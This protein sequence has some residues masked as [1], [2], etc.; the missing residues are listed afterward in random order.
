MHDPTLSSLP[1]IAPLELAPID[2]MTSRQRL[3][4]Y[5]CVFFNVL[6]GLTNGYDICVTS[7]V[8]EQMV[9]DFALCPSDAGGDRAP[10][11]TSCPRKEAVLSL[12]ATG[13]LCSKLLLAWLADHYGRRLALA[14]VDCM[15]IWAVLLQCLAGSAAVLLLGRFV[16]GVGIGLSFVVEPTYV[17]EIAPADRRGQFV[18]FN[19][20]AVCIGCLLGLQVSTVLLRSAGPRA[21]RVVVGIGAIPACVQLLFLPFL[22]ESPRWLAVQRKERELLQVAHKLGLPSKELH[23]LLEQATE[24]KALSTETC[25]LRRLWALQ[26]RAWSLYKTAF[27]MALG[28]AFFNTASGIFG[29]QAYARDVLKFSGVEKPLGLLPLVGWVKLM[30]SLVAVVC[31]D[32][33]RAGRRRLALVGST[34]CMLSDLVLAWR[35]ASPGHV[36]PAIGVLSFFLF[37]FFWNVGYGSLQFVVTTELLP[38]DVRALWAGQIFAIVG[39]VEITIYQLFETMLLADGVATFLFFAG[40]NGLAAV[41]AGCI[42]SDLG[43][44]SLEEAAGSLAAPEDP[45]GAGAGEGG[46]GGACGA[47]PGGRRGSRYGVLVE[48]QADSLPSNALSVEL[49][50][51]QPQPTVLGASAADGI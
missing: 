8:L 2:A 27:L 15:I 50:S 23:G 43:G 47:A 39:I 18:V 6:C 48:E 14:F 7:A 46:S 25:S 44:R 29:L 20:V 30:G 31:A 40:I 38:S 26:T 36:P 32:M 33:P 45:A 12:S 41:F 22:P 49:P 34:F 17:S 3:L 1:G 19:E 35:L 24:S 16:L 10:E 9:D 4:R 37:I 28:F 13:S 11:V 51:G 21:W 42:M 5:A